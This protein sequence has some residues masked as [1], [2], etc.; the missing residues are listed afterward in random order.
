MQRT[1]SLAEVEGKEGVV[2]LKGTTLLY[3]ARP[4]REAESAS[5]A[6]QQ[7]TWINLSQKFSEPLA[8]EACGGGIVRFV[9]GRPLCLPRYRL[10]QS[11]VRRL[12]LSDCV[13]SGGALSEEN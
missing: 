4:P 11:N 6:L 9:E 5:M 1:D 13:R 7:S 10:L 2:S 8:G 12:G 3:K